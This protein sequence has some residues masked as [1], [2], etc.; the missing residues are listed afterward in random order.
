M[1]RVHGGLGLGLSI[2]KS[3]V[4]LHGGSV[5][6]TSGGEG[7]GATFTV[8][9]PLAVV[10]AAHGEMAREHPKAPSQSSAEVDWPTLAGVRVLVV[11]DEPDA[12]SL[13]KRV[14]EE[15]QAEVLVACSAAEALDVVAAAR[16][17]VIVSD[18]GMPETDGYALNAARHAP[19]RRES[20]SR[21][22]DSVCSLGGSNSSAS[23]RVSNPY[24]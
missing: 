9:L 16:P 11:D 19:A 1:A 13:I 10:H 24:R 7:N 17:D 5:H 15:S 2:V 14:L 20:P 12:R 3:L 4:E 8:H 22:V 23:S 21:S 6:A 18:I